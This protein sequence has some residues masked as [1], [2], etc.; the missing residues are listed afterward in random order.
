MVAYVFEKEARMRRTLRRRWA[1]GVTVLLVAACLASAQASLSLKEILAKNLEASGGQARLAQVQNLSFKTGGMRN[2]VSA[3]GE[4]KIL[5]GKEPVITE[6]VLAVGNKV[7]RNSFGTVSDIAEPQRTVY[8]TLAKLYAGL[9]SLAGFDGQL[10]LVGLRSFGP[11]K[12]Y[13]LTTVSQ[14]GPI[15]VHFY[16][17]ADDCR[18]KRLVFQGMTPEGDKYEVNYDF[19]PFEDVEG[20]RLPMSWFVSQVGTR[21][22]LNEVADVKTNQ[23]LDKDFFTKLDINAGKAEASPGQMKGNVLD[24]SSSPY[25]LTIVTNWTR[26]D[27]EAAGFRTGDRLALNFDGAPFDLTFYALPNEIP[28]IGDLTKGARLLVPILRGGEAFAIQVMGEDVAAFAAKL[29]PL[30]PISVKKSAK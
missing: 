1:A 3:S 17:L 12:L 9:F 26:R 2:V 22:T 27:V 6:T 29:K 11:E 21:G 28:P 24:F 20:L 13:H 30:A 5:G 4:L 15:S 18:L 23:T 19:A 8:K 10:K 16:L 25:G 14:L 7:R